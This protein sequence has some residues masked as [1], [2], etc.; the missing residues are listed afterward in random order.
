MKYIIDTDDYKPLFKVTCIGLFG[1]GK[2]YDDVED[3]VWSRMVDVDNLEELNAEYV[4]EHFSFLQDDAYEQGVNDA[5]NEKDYCEYCQYAGLDASDHPC[6]SCSNSHKNL[7][8]PQ[9]KTAKRKLEVGDEVSIKPFGM[10]AVVI[11]T[12]GEKFV[13]TL[14]AEGVLIGKPI[15]DVERTGRTFDEAKDLMRD[16]IEKMKE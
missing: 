13:T 14:D 16:L 4:N 8:K 6:R 1:I 2:T 15:Q 7:F 9:E 12:D 3:T 5:N 11:D 10:K